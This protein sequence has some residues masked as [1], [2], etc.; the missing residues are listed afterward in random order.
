M[1]APTIWLSLFVA[2]FAYCRHFIPFNYFFIEQFTFF[3]FSKEY[4]LSTIS[5]PGGFGNY[6]ANFLTQ[7]Y[8]NPE[9]GPLITAGLAVLLTVLLDLCLKH[10][11]PKYYIPFLSALPALACIWIE[12]DHNYYLSG[13]V[14]LILIMASFL[15]YLKSSRFIP[16]PV[17]LVLLMLLSWPI[18]FLLGPNALLMVGLCVLS[19]L[20]FS[21]KRS[22]LILLTLPVAVACPVTLYYMDLGNELRFQLLPEGYYLEILKAPIHTYFPWI[23]IVLNVILARVLSV[24]SSDR[25]MGKKTLVDRFTHSVWVIS[26]QFV[27]IVALMHWG[28]K[29]YN[30]SN[31]YEAKVFDY[32]VRTGRW[33][34]LLQDDHLRSSQNFL[35]AC[36]QNLA[37]SSLNLMGDKLFACPQIGLPVL[38][39]RWNRSAN[40]STLLSD[41]YWQMGDVALAQEMAFEG[42]VACRDAVNPRLLM[43]LVQTNLVAGNYS[44]AAKYINLLSD[45]YYYADQAEYYRQMLYKDE[46][47]LADAELGPRKKGMLSAPGLTSASM[48]IKD[49]EFII[50]NNPEFIPAFHY[51]GSMCLLSKNLEA[52]VEFIERFYDAPALSKMPMHFQEAIVISFENNPE[53]WEELGVSP[54]VK[55]RYEAYRKLFITYRNSPILERKMAASFHDTYWYH[56]MFKK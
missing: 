44:V 41:V 14:T 49:L 5:E 26:L 1:L 45:T 8:I 4:A 24:F 42:M 15:L 40:T 39:I 22:W 16:F 27:A 53:R 32:Y 20:K 56:Y 28:V 12:T 36:Y 54:V 17:R 10:L 31:N 23:G 35:H 9:I 52:F 38:I 3:R 29:E 51:Y 34:D 18:D 6:C 30:S 37:L 33:T 11:S 47:V 25:E 46:A 21:D 19:E 48:V 2:I 7:F 50:R 55:E 43:R 13:T